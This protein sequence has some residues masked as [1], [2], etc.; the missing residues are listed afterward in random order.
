MR[1]AAA[2]A[3]ALLVAFAVLTAWA[4]EAG[5]VAV[6][7]TERPGGGARETHV[8]WVERGGAVELEAATPERA[9]LAGALAAGEVVLE[10]DGRR[11]RFRAERSEEPGARERLRAALR[12]KYGLR[13][14][15]VGLLQ[16]TSRSVA[17]RLAPLARVRFDR[18][19]ETAAADLPFSDA[20]RAGG[21]LFVSGQLGVRPGES[22][23]VPGG[24]EAET[25]QAL[26]NI[27]AILARSGASLADVVK[28]TAFLADMDDWPQMNAVYRRYFPSALPARSALGTAGLAYDARIELECI[29]AA[30]GGE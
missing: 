10:R 2:A 20:A 21:L 5:D 11:E 4:L 7:V 24:I 6:L 3:I 14:A 9:W 8:W 22:K 19:P 12:Q 15:W 25:A 16:D 13:D 29:A 23:V 28:C 27:R 1:R 17:V 26:D 30:P 18:S